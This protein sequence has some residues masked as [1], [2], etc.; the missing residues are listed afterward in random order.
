MLPESGK[1]MLLQQLK[2]TTKKKYPPELRCF[3]LT[4]NFYSSSA[5]DY[6][7]KTFGKC[8]PHP[9]T[10]RKWYC[11]IDGSPGYT[12]EAIRAV[13]IK[14]EEMKLK[15]KPLLCSLMKDEMAIREHI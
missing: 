15:N 1:Q 14:V 13:R 7:R 11:S 8:L 10:L 9:S 12:T 3:A 4:L 6:V 2:I 5:Y